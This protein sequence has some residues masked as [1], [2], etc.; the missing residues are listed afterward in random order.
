VQAQDENNNGL[1]WSE[2]RTFEVDLEQPTL[3]PAT[4][5]LGDAS[6]PVLRWFPVPRAG[7]YSLQIHEPDGSPPSTYTGFPSTAASFEKITG[8]G[9]FTWEIRAD[10][11]KLTGG[12][13]PAPWRA[14][15]DS[16]HHIN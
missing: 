11:P 10:F 9:L 16:T 1:T 14:R 12:T 6:L 13:P 5:A 8:T 4:P 3:D 2:I 15:R 7:Y